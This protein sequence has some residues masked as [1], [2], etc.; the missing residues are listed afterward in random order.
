[1][2]RASTSAALAGRHSA[3][4]WTNCAFRRAQVKRLDGVLRPAHTRESEAAHAARSA[5]I[6]EPKDGAPGRDEVRH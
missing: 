3:F 4:A 2:H 1:M 5:A 6:A